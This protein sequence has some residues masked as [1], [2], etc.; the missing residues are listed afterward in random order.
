M[1][2]DA[3]A[4]Q[5][6]RLLE[7]L[8]IVRAACALPARSSASIRRHRRR[9]AHVVG[10]R[11]ERETPER[12][13]RPVQALAEVALDLARTGVRFWAAVDLVD[14]L[15]HARRRRRVASAMRDQRLDVLRK[16][17]AA[18][19][20]AGE[21]EGGADAP[22][23]ADA[24]A[25]VLDVAA[26]RLA[27]VGDLVHQRDARRQHGVGGVLGHLGALRAHHQDRVAGAHERLVEL[28]HDGQGVLAVAADDDAVGLLEV[29]DRG[30]FLE[31][32]RVGDDVERM[33]RAGA[34]DLPDARGGADRHGA[35]VDD[36][37]VA[38]HRVADLSATFSTAPRSA[39]PFA[40]SGVPT[41]MKQS[42]DRRT[43]S[44]RSV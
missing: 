17:G 35:L 38:I 40:P 30:A 12:E 42:S 6:P 41:A 10:A 43:A 33:W 1:V 3:V 25:H 20:D 39:S 22:V 24:A 9:L 7:R 2:A 18:V 31:E 16:A 28:R 19:P 8:R 29:L 5:T 44:V 37:P 34:N 27:Q 14:R 13:A 36:D 32:L 23:E 15:Q 21:E 26:D 11:L 4:E